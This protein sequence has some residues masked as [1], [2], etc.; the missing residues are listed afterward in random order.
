MLIDTHCHLDETGFDPDRDEVIARA[1]AAGIGRM[2]T[3]GID[4]ATSRAAVELADR[5]DSVWA[6][7]GVQPNYVTQVPGDA[8]QTVSELASHPKV[9]AI[10]ET[11]LDLYWDHAP[12]AAQQDW[13]DWHLEL[14]A[15]RSLPFIVHCRDAEAETVAQLQ[16]ASASSPLVGVMHSFCGS[17]ETAD[18]CLSLGLHLSYSGMVTYP[19]NA[20]LRATAAR[21]PA[22]RLLVETDAPY[23]APVP[24]R[25][26]RNE[27]SF[28]AHTAAVLAEARGVGLD[29]LASATT[30]N[31]ERLFGFGEAG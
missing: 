25:G 18:A 8:R 2:L 10:G 15:E 5:F 1:V 20:S 4:V 21:T 17:D 19:K 24:K 28:V 11:G 23:L 9:V 22:D 7:V 14:A 29:E 26:K 30:A 31:A 12:L 16:R 13:F 3:I 27:P 6:V